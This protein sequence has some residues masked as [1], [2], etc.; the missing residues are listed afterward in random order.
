MRIDNAQVDYLKTAIEKCLPDAE[1]YLF[2]SRVRDY[3]KGGDIDLLIIGSRQLT[4]QEKRD[5][6]IGFYKNFEERKIDLVSFTK[7]DPAPFKQLALMEA[8]RL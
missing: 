6:K 8:K 2:G 7:E 3:L 4:D 1:V 5:V